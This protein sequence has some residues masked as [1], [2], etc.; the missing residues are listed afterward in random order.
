MARAAGCRANLGQWGIIYAAYVADNDGYL[1]TYYGDYLYKDLELT[2]ITRESANPLTNDFPCLASTARS[3]GFTAVKGI[4]ICPMAA[5]PIEPNSLILE[6][7]R[8]EVYEDF[9]QG[10]WLW[11]GTFRAW[12]V[13]YGDTS[14]PWCW[15]GSYCVNDQAR[16]WWPARQGSPD[17]STRLTWKWMTNAVKNADKVPVYLDGAWALAELFNEKNRPPQ[18]DA[19]P[20]CHYAVSS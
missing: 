12:A 4:A 11:G 13:W 6:G 19:I 17:A 3:P 14:P 18:S 15:R 20:T 5:K 16:S 7:V 8:S 9:T 2:T 10:L 1:P